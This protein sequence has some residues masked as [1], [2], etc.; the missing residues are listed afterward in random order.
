MCPVLPLAVMMGVTLK[1]L[2]RQVLVGCAAPQG[3]SARDPPGDTRLFYLCNSGYTASA[4]LYKLTVV[5]SKKNVGSI[6]RK[7]VLIFW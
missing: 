5:T 4:A 6:S 2:P 1:P 7:C 3:G